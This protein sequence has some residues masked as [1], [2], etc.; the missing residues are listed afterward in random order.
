MG[1]K[2]KKPGPREKLVDA[3]GDEDLLFADGFDEAI[4]GSVAVWT[5]A[6]QQRV[7]LYDYEKCVEIL[8]REE[9]A[10][11]E[12]V[13]EHLDVNTLGS[14]VGEKTPAYAFLTMA[15]N[16]AKRPGG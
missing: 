16:M 11:R 4:I 3:V 7:V 14:Y 15:E 10:E 8:M 13:E 6:G 1:R 5:A 12:E 9:G 2:P